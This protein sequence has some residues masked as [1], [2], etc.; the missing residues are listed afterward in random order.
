MLPARPRAPRD[1]AGATSARPR[2]AVLP[3]SVPA[4][5][6][7][8]LA[9]QPLVEPSASASTADRQGLGRATLRSLGI[10]WKSATRQVEFEPL[11]QAYIRAGNDAKPKPGWHFLR[12]VHFLTTQE[13]APPLPTGVPGI[14]RHE[15]QI[16]GTRGAVQVL[17]RDDGDGFLADLRIAKSSEPGDVRRDAKAMQRQAERSAKSRAAKL[18]VTLAKGKKAGSSSAAGLSR[19][20][21]PPH[22]RVWI[23]RKAQLASL[24]QEY[25][26]GKKEEF[27][28]AQLIELLQQLAEEPGRSEP[29][30]RDGIDRCSV[31]L[32]GI[33]RDIKFLM[34][35]KPGGALTDLRLVPSPK[36]NSTCW[37]RWRSSRSSA[38]PARAGRL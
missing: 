14:Q 36:K 1:Q 20:Q 31:R 3:A 27:S 18:R 9:T 30:G 37:T 26:R 38:S 17:R 34:H 2:N 21:Q 10:L 32:Q 23:F 33:D 22:Q 4:T 13:D 25:V 16:Q 7:Q 6:S 28:G 11:R 35:R 8:P 19:T 12:L 5:S 15:V 24:H 29:T